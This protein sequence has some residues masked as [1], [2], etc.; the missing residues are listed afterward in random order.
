MSSLSYPLGMYPLAIV[1][2]TTVPNTAGHF[3]KMLLPTPIL[4]EATLSPIGN[5]PVTHR[6]S[7][8]EHGYYFTFD[9][10]AMTTLRVNQSS[11][12]CSAVDVR[13]YHIT[14]FKLPDCDWTFAQPFYIASHVLEAPYSITAV[15]LSSN[16]SHLVQQPH[17]LSDVTFVRNV[18]LFPSW[19]NTAACELDD[20]TE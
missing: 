9:H 16:Q 10:S 17:P 20:S 14:G 13:V 7:V 1:P 2:N 15:M 8:A 12:N 18:A 6:P 19:A 11:C 3:L 5:D 4:D